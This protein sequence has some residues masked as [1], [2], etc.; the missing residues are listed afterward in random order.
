MIFTIQMEH[1]LYV[2]NKTCFGIVKTNTEKMYGDGM[3]PVPE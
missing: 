2:N 3:K 1:E